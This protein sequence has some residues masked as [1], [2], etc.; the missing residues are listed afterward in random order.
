[1]L[2]ILVRI[3]FSIIS[4]TYIQTFLPW[5]ARTTGDIFNFMAHARFHISLGVKFQWGVAVGPV[6]ADAQP[7][8]EMVNWF[9]CAAPTTQRTLSRAH[10]ILFRSLHKHTHSASQKVASVSIIST[11][12]TT[13]R[14]QAVLWNLFPVC[15]LSCFAYKCT[16]LDFNQELFIHKNCHIGIYMIAVEFT[17]CT[18]G[19][20]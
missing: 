18:S 16:L 17:L 7:R 15:V 13:T 12:I 3:Y 4:C 1:M 19:I 20:K 11:S 6:V 5:D 14:T 8:K 2:I 9:I 10:L